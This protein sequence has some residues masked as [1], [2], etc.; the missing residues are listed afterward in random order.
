MI[1][2]QSL[3]NIAVMMATLA[4]AAYQNDNRQIFADLGFD[5]YKA[6]DI[7]GAYGHLAANSKE[8]IITCRGTQP[9]DINDLLADLDTIPKRHGPGWVHEGFRR[10]ARKLLD[11]I[12]AWMKIHRGKDVYITGHSLGA[13]MATYITQELEYAKHMWINL[14]TFGSPRLGNEPYVVELRAPHYRFVNCNDIVTHVPPSVMLFKHHGTLCYINFY[15]NIRPLSKWQR[16]KDMMRAHWRAWKKAELFDGLTDHSI[17][18]Y[19]TKLQNIR[20][21]G[22]RIN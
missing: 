5:Q 3:E 22:Q 16:F 15:G 18:S 10:E 14:Y 9:T 13:A 12:L 21:T 8:V 20:D 2:D 7:D 11:E 1:K 17:Q 19:I 4:G 6:L